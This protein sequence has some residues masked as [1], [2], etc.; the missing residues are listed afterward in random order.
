V[1]LGGVSSNGSVYIQA[2]VAT[3]NAILMQL[4]SV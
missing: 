1:V 3:V 2:A 4:T